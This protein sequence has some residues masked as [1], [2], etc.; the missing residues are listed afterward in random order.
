MLD[1]ETKEEAEE[2]RA[3]EGRQRGERER[4]RERERESRINMI[5]ARLR[6][7]AILRALKLF[8]FHIRTRSSFVISFQ[9][10]CH[11]C[12]KVVRKRL[13]SITALPW[14]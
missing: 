13:T 8:L 4:E 14:A 3:V 1:E 6:G 7:K 10:N 9:M 5:V 2:A 11:L 12:P